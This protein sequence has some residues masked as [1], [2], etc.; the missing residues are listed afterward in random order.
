MMLSKPRRVV[1]EDYLEHLRGER[2]ITCGAPPRSDPSH[3]HSRG[4]GGS[5]FTAASQCR[6]CHSLF[7]AMGPTR[8]MERT[9]TNPWREQSAQVVAYLT[10][11]V[12]T[13]RRAAELVADVDTEMTAEMTAQLRRLFS[14]LERRAG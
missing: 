13:L 11:T 1:D 5:D 3:L 12:V 2:C 4:A 6:S 10:D 14:A 7:H 8:F 9:G